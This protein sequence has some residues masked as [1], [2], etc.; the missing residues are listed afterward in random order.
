[1]IDI[2]CHILP[3]L[4]DGAKHTADSVQMAKEAVLH[5]IHTIIATPHHQN[6]KYTNTKNNILI[7]VN[8]LNKR[9]EEEDIPLTVLS[10]QESRISGDMVE[11]I[12]NGQLL[13]LNE[14]SCYIFLELPSNHVPRYTQQLLF[15]LQLEGYKP[16]IVHPERNKELIENPNILYELVKKGTLTQITAASIV[17]KFGKKIQ[18]FSQDLIEH[19]LTHFL[20][21]D[22]HNTTSRGFCMAESIN[23]IDKTYGNNMVYFFMENAQTLIQGGNVIG[24]VPTRLKKKKFLGLL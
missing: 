14:T 6:G 17:G 18:R 12:K 2:H 3:G 4:D 19:N 22:A 24:D 15:D 23:E 16:I 21:S 8:R 1:M 11:G 13:C 9:L 10:G 7:E 5:G 20:A